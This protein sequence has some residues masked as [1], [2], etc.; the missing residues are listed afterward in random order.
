MKIQEDD[1]ISYRSTDSDELS[2]DGSIVSPTT[3]SKKRKKGI[4]IAQNILSECDTAIDFFEEMN[5]S[6]FFQ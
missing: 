1:N 5:N 4:K 6:I 3:V 2:L